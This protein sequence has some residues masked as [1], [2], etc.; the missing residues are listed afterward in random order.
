[1]NQR[2]AV[3]LS[4]E[5]KLLER[6]D[7]DFFFQ[8]SF[9]GKVMEEMPEDLK[10]RLEKWLQRLTLMGT[11]QS[12]VDRVQRNDYLSRLY[13]C[14][15][16]KQLSSPFDHNPPDGLLPTLKTED[17]Y[18]EENQPDWVDQLTEEEGEC[19]HVGGKEFE[20]YL[21]TKR[22]DNNRGSCA[23]LACSVL[24]EGAEF[25]FKDSK[26]QSIATGLAGKEKMIEK[27]FQRE[28]RKRP[29]KKR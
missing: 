20:T 24:N 23:Y 29:A 27:W 18:L 8:M 14:A 21:S 3:I 17:R 2:S 6:L 25:A 4:P 11:S 19:P 9:F 22:F 12:I 1:M 10:P 28:F 16:A 26:P 7:E 15:E 13:Q 5:Q